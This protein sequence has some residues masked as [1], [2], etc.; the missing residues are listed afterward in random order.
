MTCRKKFISV[1]NE[2][3]KFLS[4]MDKRTAVGQLND[5]TAFPWVLN[6]SKNF[7]AN[8]RILMN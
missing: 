8:Y 7:S 1:W 3:K 5:T 6:F 4:F 2:I